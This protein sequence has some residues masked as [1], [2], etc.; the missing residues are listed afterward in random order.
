MPHPPEINLTT[1]IGRQF[2]KDYMPFPGNI[3]NSRSSDGG[4]E[5]KNNSISSDTSSGN[6][7][8][9]GEAEEQYHRQQGRVGAV[10]ALGA[11]GARVIAAGA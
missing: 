6:N 2:P 1:P 7:K 11:A 4:S 3:N 8:S 10:A 9:D 5:N